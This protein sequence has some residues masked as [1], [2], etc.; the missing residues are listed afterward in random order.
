MIF[1]HVKEVFIAQHR[2]DFR[3][4]V[5][6]MKAEMAKLELDP[7]AGDCCVFIH[8][9]HRQIRVVGASSTGCFL[10]IKVFEAGALKQKMRFL[11]DPSFV[12]ISKLEL[13][14]LLEGA[15]TSKL[16]TVPDWVA[17]KNTRSNVTTL[18]DENTNRRSLS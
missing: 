11:R 8:P 6:G 17:C 14:L 16:E 15:T 7:Y 10:I 5:F 9:S 3:L 2:V 18:L 1:N 4:G 13:S 12:E